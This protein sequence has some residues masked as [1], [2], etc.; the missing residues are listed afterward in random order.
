MRCLN[1]R[2]DREV[3]DEWAFCD[4]CGRDNRPPM[5]RTPVA[6]DEH[7][8]VEGEFCVRCGRSVLE[9]EEDP[10]EDQNR[11]YAWA[12]WTLLIA[13]GASLAFS[14][15]SRPTGGIKTGQEPSTYEL[16]YMAS[17]FGAYAFAAGVILLL[18]TPNL[19]KRRR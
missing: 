5:A 10:D 17:R 1:P 13:G 14:Q 7:E 19:R 9:I 3:R 6:V 4:L 12:G 18:V 16:A 11:L 8:I 15:F 2:C